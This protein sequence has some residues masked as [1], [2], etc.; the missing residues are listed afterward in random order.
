MND[1]YAEFVGALG[2]FELGGG[3]RRAWAAST[4]AAGLGRCRVAVIPTL[5]RAVAAR[6]APS[7]CAVRRGTEPVGR[8]VAVR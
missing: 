1:G 5:R 8:S 7:G 4:L 2:N 6:V 3:V